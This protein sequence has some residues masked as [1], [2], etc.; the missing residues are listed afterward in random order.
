[1]GA[2]FSIKEDKKDSFRFKKCPHCNKFGTIYVDGS[3]VTYG[4]IKWITDSL[5]RRISNTTYCSNK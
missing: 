1:M 2:K 4:H 5:G 3:K